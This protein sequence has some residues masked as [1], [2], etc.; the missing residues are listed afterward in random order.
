MSINLNL[1][2]TSHCHLCEQAESLLVTLSKQY[3]IRWMLVEITDDA[4]LLENYGIKIP[5]LKR[6]SDQ[7][8]IEWPFTLVD[9]ECFIKAEPTSE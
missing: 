6:L 2:S 1:Y 4:E 8:E 5:V 9:I 7:S 3:D